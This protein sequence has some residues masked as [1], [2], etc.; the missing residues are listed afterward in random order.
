MFS[1]DEI[2]HAALRE[3][4]SNSLDFI[5]KQHPDSLRR[6]ILFGSCARGEETESSDIDLCLVFDDTAEIT[7]RQMRLYKGYLRCV[8]EYERDIV[9]CNQKHLVNQ[10]QLIYRMINRD[11]KTLLDL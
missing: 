7:S 4:V 11:G 5:R 8:D 1:V 6:V 2:K 9:F 3:A 10:E